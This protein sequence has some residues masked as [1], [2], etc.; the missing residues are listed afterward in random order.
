MVFFAPVLA[1][2]LAT[3]SQATGDVVVIARPHRHYHYHPYDDYYYET[4]PMTKTEI[5]VTCVVLGVVVLAI[6]ISFVVWAI[7]YCCQKKQEFVYVEQSTPAG[8]AA[9]VA[10][11]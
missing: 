1:A 5:I 11:V 10:A 8:Q 6:L 7:I 3:F 2:L 9:V 4:R